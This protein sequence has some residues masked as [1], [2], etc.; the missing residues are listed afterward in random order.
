MVGQ[1]IWGYLGDHFEKKVPILFT[2]IVGF[3]FSLGGMV[4]TESPIG[5]IKH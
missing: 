1:L 5:K 3:S 4:F 2:T